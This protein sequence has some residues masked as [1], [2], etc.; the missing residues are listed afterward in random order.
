MG[1]RRYI[2]LPLRGLRLPVAPHEAP[3]RV[4]G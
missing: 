1:V 3:V 4:G 2:T